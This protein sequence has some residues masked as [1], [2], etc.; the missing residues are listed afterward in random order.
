MPRAACEGLL[1]QLSPEGSPSHHFLPP[2]GAEFAHHHPP[3]AATGWF[4]QTLPAND[5]HNHLFTYFCTIICLPYFNI[6]LGT[7]RPGR[8]KNAEPI[9]CKNH[10][11]MRV[12]INGS[13]KQQLGADW[14]E[15]AGRSRRP[16]STFQGLFVP[17]L[18]EPGQ[19]CTVGSC[20]PMLC[21]AKTLLG[22]S[23]SEPSE[24]SCIS[25][26]VT[27][28]AW[29][30]SLKTRALYLIWRHNGNCCFHWQA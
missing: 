4:P 17:F 1:S 15:T 26:N 6:T 23:L 19:V 18:M 22:R 29:L 25:K 21:L 7:S 14:L 2:A 24:S 9:P 30:N 12:I 16:Q 3:A 27:A 5:L 8:R 20:E 28:Q 13:T 10:Q 11:L